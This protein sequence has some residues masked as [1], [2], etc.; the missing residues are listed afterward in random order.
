MERERDIQLEFIEKIKRTVGDGQ[1]FLVQ[2]FGCQMN[3]HDSEKIIGMLTQMGY[4]QADVE[5]DA[6]IIVYN[7]CCVRENAENRV[8]GNLGYLKHMKAAKPSLKIV[9]CGCM[10]QQSTV[11]E[12]IKKAYRHVDAIFGTFNLYRL[13][14]ILYT[15]IETGE[16]IIDIWEDYK[17]IVEDLPSIRSF[18]F[19]AG[20]NIMYGCNNF[21]SYCIVP[22][23]RGRERS[24]EAADIIGEIK[25]LAADGVKEV[26]LLG[27]NVNSYGRGLTEPKSFAELLRDVNA[28][29]GI[30]RI[31][32]MTSHPKDLSDA[33]IEAIRDCDKVC[34]HIHLPVQSGS[35]R[36]LTAM[37]RKY[38]KE[39]Y[40]D[41]IKRIKT[42]I[43]DIAVTTDIIVG[44]PGE[45]DEDF[46]DTLDVVREAGF[47][48]AFTF[49]YSERTG[50]PAAQFTD[51]VPQDVV[52]ERFN[53]LLEALNA[54]V[55]EINTSL[56]GKTL[57]VLAEDVNPRDETLLAGRLEN[58]TLVHF[59]GDK[60]L[61]GCIT[62][63]KITGCKTFY[64]TGEA[65]NMED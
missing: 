62:D 8:Y 28:I 65:Q 1:K 2:T 45:T 43:P 30:E 60:N 40:L 42:A 5:K 47:S 50:T 38:T 26:M 35:T 3:A 14:Q 52:N 33:L 10:M 12:K 32:F 56:V 36:L 27:Q 9:L 7:T 31:R 57:P 22:Y 53:R 41:L 23:V 13:P 21:C 19:K 24:R 64:L 18:K 54:T 51:K 11:I 37:N 17:E 15:C 58:N 48:S 63:V 49:I 46:N 55:L 34:K 25:G 4:T 39:Q 59:A 29:D 44:F 16:Q 6:D 61:V 20:V